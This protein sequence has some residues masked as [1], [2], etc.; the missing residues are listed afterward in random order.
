MASLESLPDLIL[1]DIFSK[2]EYKD[3]VSLSK[4]SSAMNKKVDIFLCLNSRAKKEEAA[5]WVESGNHDSLPLV[6]LPWTADLSQQEHLELRVAVRDRKMKAEEVRNTLPGKLCPHYTNPVPRV[7]S[8][9][10]PFISSFCLGPAYLYGL[11]VRSREEG[12]FAFCVRADNFQALWVEKISDE[13]PQQHSTRTAKGYL[14]VGYHFLRFDGASKEVPLNIA[15]VR[16]GKVTHRNTGIMVGMYSTVQFG[17]RRRHL[18]VLESDNYQAFIS[19]IPLDNFNELASNRLTVIERSVK[20]HRAIFFAGNFLITL[21]ESYAFHPIKSRYV[22]K[23]IIRDRHTAEIKR[24]DRFDNKKYSYLGVSRDGIIILERRK[25]RPFPQPD[26]MKIAL[27]A[28]MNVRYMK[29]LISPGLQ[30]DIIG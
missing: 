25:F 11:G 23:I 24:V 3:L 9:F 2:M 26:E 16:N 30:E 13:V 27:M 20:P 1:W 28:P 22:G 21:T 18:E 7:E 8:G 14:F 5:V 19:R 4:T 29:S 15:V 12:L 10:R 6:E 17:I